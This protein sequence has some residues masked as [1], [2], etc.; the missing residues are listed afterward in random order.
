MTSPKGFAHNSTFMTVDAPEI[1]VPYLIR[2]QIRN[3]IL[4]GTQANKVYL[5]NIERLGESFKHFGYNC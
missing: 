3:P 1:A 4:V 5:R 2:T